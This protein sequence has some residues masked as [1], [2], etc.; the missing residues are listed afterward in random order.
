MIDSA[1]PHETVKNARKHCPLYLRL[2]S[3]GVPPAG[4]ISWVNGTI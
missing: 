2:W 4:T 3:G 1:P